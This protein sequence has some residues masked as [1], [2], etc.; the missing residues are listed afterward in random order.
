MNFSYPITD[1]ELEDSRKR[2]RQFHLIDEA[3]A[4]KHCLEK[5]RL[6]E[7]ERKNISQIAE[8]MMTSLRS[9][10]PPGHMEHFFRE[11]GLSNPEGVALMSLAEALPRIPDVKTQNALI[12]DK[13]VPCN[14]SQHL[15]KRNPLSVNLSTLGLLLGK[16]ILQ[17][18]K[19][20]LFDALLAVPRTFAAPIIRKVLQNN[21]RKLSGHFVLATSIED[22]IENARFFEEQG[23][24]YS[25]DMLGEAALTEADAQAYFHAYSNAILALQDVALH[26]DLHRNPGISVKLSALHPRYEFAQHEAVMRELVPRVRILAGQAKAANI[27]FN[28]DAEEAERLSLSLEV[29]EAV[30]KDKGLANWNGFGVTV[31]SYNKQCMSVLDWLYALAQNL[32]RRI[33]VRLVKG[34]YWDSEIKRA[35]VFGLKDFPVFTR[36]A[37]TDI[38]YLASTQK[39]FRMTDYIT[40]QLAT[41]NAHSIVSVI[42]FSQQVK[43]S[44]IYSENSK[45]FEFQCLHGMGQAL[46]E[47]VRE[48]YDFPCRIYAPVGAY[49]DLLPYLVRRLLENGANSSF[50]HQIIDEDIPVAQVVEDPIDKLEASKDVSSEVSHNPALTKP[51]HLFAPVRRNSK[52]YDLSDPEDAHL[53]M[54]ECKV[55]REN[56]WNY[57]KNGLQGETIEIFNPANARDQVGCVTFASRDDA[58]NAFRKASEAQVHWENLSQT[59]RSKV[60]RF[61]A[62][63]YQDHTYEILG[64]LCREAGKTFEDGILELR[65][66]IDFLRFY[67]S[68][69]EKNER[70]ARGIFVCISPWNFPLAIFTGQ[71]AATLVTGNA[72]LAKPA[73]QTPLIASLAVQLLH[74]AG[75]PQDVLKLL[76]GTGD[77]IGTFLTTSPRVSGL[78]FTG[79]T[80]T[81][82]TINQALAISA[83]QAPLVAE[84]GGVNAM[85]VDSTA[86][87]EQT[88]NDILASAFQSAGQRCS[89]LRMLYIQ[90]DIEKP[91]LKMLFG[92]MDK[93]QVGDPWDLPTDVGPLIDKQ[94]YNAVMKYCKKMED[95][96]CLLKKIRAPALGNFVPPTAFRVS[97]IKDISREVFGPVLH[98]ARFEAKEFDRVVSDINETG[99][100][101]T[102][103]LQ[104]RI[105]SRV[106]KISATLNV[107]NI[108]V[109]RN[110]IGAV[111][112]AQ[113]FGGQGLSGTGPKAGGPYYL[114]RFTKEDIREI[115]RTF[116]HGHKQAQRKVDPIGL[117]DLQNTLEQLAKQK[118][119][120]RP[121]QITKLKDIFKDH[122]I[123]EQALEVI[124]SSFKLNHALPGPT[125]E[126][127]RLLLA[128][129][130]TFLCLGPDLES[131]YA[132]AVQSLALK[133]KALIIAREDP[134]QEMVDA[135]KATGLPI[136]FICG[137]VEPDTLIEIPSI[138]GVAYADFNIDEEYLR[139]MRY[140]LA[141][142]P[143]PILPVITDL[144]AP[145]A[146]VHERIICV[147]TAA[148]GGNVDLMAIS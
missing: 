25:Y 44:G 123:A 99:Y 45:R 70:A 118:P 41:H 12:S 80:Q 53:I 9:E 95:R 93:L 84:T 122:P 4:V 47:K 148:I 14:W 129:R 56:F 143:G 21:I 117:E 137:L 58:S 125:G 8:K 87:P 106:R 51:E 31:Q 83:P 55:F 90:S 68:E 38:N 54:D 1:I 3:E 5:L 105:E 144:I 116:S 107:S 124:A 131:A 36:K 121:Q 104:S 42:H 114:R 28:I 115:V 64:L 46:Y 69:A 20:I 48:T 142:R 16:F 23:Y 13:L 18:P 19:N 132:Q 72:V 57:A 147:N 136:Q 24:T 27:G 100:G 74:R 75:V 109:N 49:E 88:V 139:D 111:V 32:N 128:S 134:P 85:I 92:A 6:S 94:A 60:L 103:G 78:C 108:Y 11:Y 110:Q 66:A 127:N 81:A 73:E 29:I 133:G 10:A 130:G 22:A 67:A 89:A 15:N 141:N 120:K 112:G 77:E 113:P 82:Q 79:S 34:A 26:D 119:L 39:L 17:N 37:H 102:F 101:L 2:L 43:Y 59:E 86:Q 50:I 71:I 98:I 7:T 146:Y 126:R 40:P 91:F 145:E 33:C 35:Q 52:G 76:P 140:A 62:D 63:L 61:A 138:A 30:L 97:G 96:E 65:E 135:L